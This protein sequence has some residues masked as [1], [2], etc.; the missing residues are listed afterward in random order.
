MKLL[1]KVGTLAL[2]AA[3][4]MGSVVG[5]SSSLDK[6][7]AAH[8]DQGPTGTVGLSLQPVAGITVNTVHYIVS[9]GATVVT[10]GDLPT[11]GTASTFSFG[12]PL[13][14]GTGYTISLSGSAVESATTTCVG[15]FGP[16]NVTANTSLQLKMVL[17]CTDASTGSINGG[18]TVQTDSCPHLI[19]DYVVATPSTANAP[20]GTIAALGSAHD[21]DGKP[22]TYA[23]TIGDTSVGAFAPANANN[24]TFTCAGAGTNVVATLTA[25]NGQCSKA[26]TTT[27]SCASVTCGNGKLDPGEQCD[28]TIP[29]GQ[30]G[31]GPCPANCHFTCGN[32]IVE[33]PAEQCDPVPPD[34]NNCTSTCQIR[35]A[36]CGDGFLENGEACDPSVPG[37]TNCNPDCTKNVPAVCGDGIVEAGEVCDPVFTKN[38]CGSDCKSITSATCAACENTTPP[39]AHAPNCPATSCDNV[40][41]VAAAG[42]SAGVAKSNLCNEVLDCVRK[43][44]CAQG[45]V[46]LFNCYCGAADP[47][48]CL[49]A[50]KGAC[51]T[52]LQAGLE[53]TDFNT[54]QQRIGDVTFGGGKAM[55]RVNCDQQVCDNTPDGNPSSPTDHSA[56]F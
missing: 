10:Q 42:P 15:S 1:A 45:G 40:T 47:T 46:S 19:V 34:P 27:V 8:K 16:F 49:T 39:G 21:T 37:T 41:G 43:S 17:T 44:N 38:D 35:P 55:D 6:Q 11:P 28:P 29:A 22:I 51:V 52:Q 56:C 20:G 32:G 18:V 24:S 48:T 7:S 13:P 53:T 26:L 31:F 50:P 23:W 5:C 30:P 36:V 2:V 54:I 33:A 3:A 25:N 14:V 4:A 9:Q 12:L